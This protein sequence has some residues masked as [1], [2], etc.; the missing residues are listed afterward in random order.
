MNRKIGNSHMRIIANEFVLPFREGWQSHASHFLVLG[1]G[2]IFCV[3][4]YGSREGNDDV[5]IYGSFRT[6]D[7]KWSRPE[8]LTEDDGLPHWNP[9]LFRRRDGAVVLFYK[10]GKTIADWVTR[11]R[12]SYDNCRTWEASRELVAG[13]RSGGRGPVR[14][15]AIYL[16]DGS[17]LA[18]GSTERGEWKCFFDRSLDDG[19]TWKRSGDLCLPADLLA[20]YPSPEGKGIIQPAVWE[21]KEGVHALL[22][23]TEGAIF[24]TDSADAAA[25]S[26]P[27]P[28]GMP[29][30]TSG[31]DVEPLPD[32]RLVLACNPV[33]ENWGSRTP[34]S[35]YIS[36]D[37]GRSFR[38]L[39]HLTTMQGKY[40]Y[41][42]LRYAGGRLHV[43]YTWN[44]RTIQ[45]MCLDEI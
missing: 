36:E 19:V 30:N 45:Y 42:A 14:N 3:W 27:Y 16:S 25:W 2:E 18:P 7:C 22:R 24:R 26:Q 9:V 33:A 35:L 41:P 6:P 8:P 11:F 38:L 31:I 21:S 15:K 1:E 32:G 13:D 20:R 39:S 34:I 29:N 12:V 40:A 28:I 17:V 44:R 10:V 5:R 4:F 43:T 37:N 23:S